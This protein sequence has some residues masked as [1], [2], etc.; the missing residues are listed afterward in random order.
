M[1]SCLDISTQSYTITTSQ[2]NHMET[3]MTSWPL[4]DAKARFSELVRKATAEG[5]Q[6]VTVRGQEQVVVISKKTYEDL[7]HPKPSFWDFMS[8]SP[9]KGIELDLKRDSS[10]PRD[11]S[12]EIPVRHECY[13]RNHS[14]KPRQQ[15]QGLVSNDSL[16]S[17]LCQR[18]KL[19]RNPQRH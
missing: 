2:T 1:T 19:G 14:Q 3:I 5:P 15:R 7:L 11:I 17:T 13:I 8:T 12:Y 9:L 10:L 16:K 18:V 6:E 4:Q